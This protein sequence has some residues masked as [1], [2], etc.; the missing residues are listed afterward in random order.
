MSDGRHVKATVV[1]RMGFYE[2]LLT[3]VSKYWQ[4]MIN[5]ALCGL[6]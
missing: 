3:Y 1:S 4:N 6:F 5:P 2:D